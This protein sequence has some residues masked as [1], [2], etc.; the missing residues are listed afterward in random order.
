MS[1]NMRIKP[2]RGQSVAGM[3]VGAIF[4]VIGLFAAIPYLGIFGMIWTGVA[5]VITVL[6]AINVFSEE[7]I[8][9]HE[10]VI[11]DETDRIG[12]PEKKESIEERLN[13]LDGLYNKGIISMEERE[14]QRKKILND[15]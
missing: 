7:G 2:G 8:A 13:K 4:C 6:N 12:K 9:T 3:I 10:L 15:I 11:E 14:E 5:V 1:K